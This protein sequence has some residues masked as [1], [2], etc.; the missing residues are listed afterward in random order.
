MALMICAFVLMLQSATAPAKSGSATQSFEVASVR[1][2]REPPFAL[3]PIR[4]LP[5]GS[6]VATNVPLRG[7]IMYAYG[8][9]TY[10]VVEGGQSLLDERFD[11]VAKAATPQAIVRWGEV[12]PLNVMMQTLLAERFG[13]VIR[14]DDRQR[15]G[16]SLVRARADGSLGPRI[17]PTD[18]DCQVQPATSVRCSMAIMNGEMNT[19]GRR[20]ADLA[21]TLSFHL[22]SPVIDR[23]GLTGPFEFR[24]QFDSGELPM[25]SRLRLPGVGP[26]P[27]TGLPSLYTAM[28]EQL[29]LKLEA[30]RLTIPVPIVERVHAPTAN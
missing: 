26:R 7:L 22:E 21:W 5:D 17:R 10:E 20:I 6:V 15:P 30:E 4:A 13:L 19:T 2:N 14:W 29:G 16:Y 8:L 23:T 25:S 3:N 11:I 28:Q 12:G 27:P 24:L 1:P 18:D 9:E